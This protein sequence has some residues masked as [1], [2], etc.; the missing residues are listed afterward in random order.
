MKKIIR[1]NVKYIIRPQR[2]GS[3]V[4]LQKDTNT[5]KVDIHSHHDN[6]EDAQDV[7]EDLYSK[8]SQAE[9]LEIFRNMHDA[10]KRI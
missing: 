5:N 8:P 6:M 1:H 3:Y 4:I 9:T 7:L 2:D 10:L